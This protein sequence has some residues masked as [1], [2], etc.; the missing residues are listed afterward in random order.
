MSSLQ[1][2]MPA[3]TYAVPSR[4]TIKRRKVRKGTFSCWECKSRKTRCEFKPASSTI[5]VSCQRRELSCISQE[6]A[7]THDGDYEEVG[8]RID[9]VEALFD[10]LVGQGSTRSIQSQRSQK[11]QRAINTVNAFAGNKMRTAPPSL[12]AAGQELLNS[13]SSLSG[14]L[15]SLLPRPDI[16]L[17]ILSHGKFFNLASQML[18]QRSKMLT[19]SSTEAQQLVQ[20]SKLPSP[21]THPVFF[22][23]KLIQLALCLQQLDAPTSEQPGKL[24]LKEPIRDAAQ[25]YLDLASHH[26]TSRDSLMESLDG[27]ETLTLEA[28]YH[29]NVGNVR[30][31]W[32]TIRRA[33]GIAQLMDLP[34]LA[35]KTDQR[36]EFMWFRLIYSDRFLSLTLGLPSAVPDDS[37]ASEHLLAVNTPSERLQRIHV[38]M[39]GRIIARNVRMQRRYQAKPRED[40][41]YDDYK[42][43]QDIDYELKQATRCLPT[44][45]WVLPTLH[46]VATHTEVMEKT[47]RTCAQMHQFYLLV[48]LHH[49]YLIRRLCLQSASSGVSPLHNSVDY[50]YSTFAALSAS[51]EVLSRFLVVRN[52]HNTP[53]YRGLDDKGFTAH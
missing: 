21:T 10:Q 16:T 1:L 2:P 4:S 12:Q 48:L 40:V 19:P 29:V 30:G 50:S 9:H 3:S 15:H 7:D 36:V 24:L 32:L 45:W 28:S 20:I 27:L 23:R 53:S 46:N 33:L 39:V 22:A 49:P 5:C 41:A 14:Y 17:R 43:T 35:E 47:A 44:T 42:E 13:S 31:A 37:F 51:R 8:K 11:P 26:V 52:F 25:R 34:R 18:Q 6:Y 38:V